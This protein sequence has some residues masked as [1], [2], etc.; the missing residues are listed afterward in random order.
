MT[1]AARHLERTSVLSPPSL[2]ER[3]PILRDMPITGWSG[4]SVNEAPTFWQTLVAPS[5]QQSISSIAPPQKRRAEQTNAE[6]RGCRWWEHV[7][8]RFKQLAT[9]PAATGVTAECLEMAA[10]TL[11]SVLPL[12]APSPSVVPTGEG[13]VEVFWQKNGWD[14]IIDIGPNSSTVWIRDRSTS[15]EDFGQLN[16]LRD[17]LAAVLRLLED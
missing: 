2:L 6:R 1:A 15:Q 12:T 14:V 9:E 7:Q 3:E 11:R 16:D 5:T 4:T 13:S 8:R 17:R 10:N